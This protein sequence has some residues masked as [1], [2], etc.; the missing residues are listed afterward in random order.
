MS[1]RGRQV[2]GSAELMRIA[3]ALPG[4]TSGSDGSLKRFSA[5]LLAYLTN[6]MTNQIPSYGFRHLWYRRL[7]GVELAGGAGVQL[8]VQLWFYG[9]GHVRRSHVRIGAGSRI[10]RESVL[11]CRG[12][13]EIGEHV[14]I[15]PQVAIIT[16]DHDRDA[17]GFPLRHGRVVLEDHVWVGMRAMILPG[18]RI[19]RGAVVAAGAVVTKDVEAGEVV[20]GVPARTISRRDP[21]ALEYRLS[22]PLPLFE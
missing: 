1:A 6:H 13:L 4:S 5:Q 18:V 20:A 21:A 14:S 10:N 17:P 22:E 11:D 8:G 2:L 16:A 9:P 12:G 3:P 7:L 15:S 19:G